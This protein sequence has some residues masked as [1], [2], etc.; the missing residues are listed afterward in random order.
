MLKNCLS[1]NRLFDHPTEV[2][3][4][5]CRKDT[6]IE[7]VEIPKVQCHCGEWFT[8]L[9]AKDAECPKCRKRK[10]ELMSEDEKIAIYKKVRDFLYTHPNTPKVKVSE[11]FGVPLKQLDEWIEH[12]RIIEIDPTKR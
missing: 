3:C 5:K 8:P 10:F 11:R 6:P 7:E 4:E 1:C 12:G 9:D 2:Y